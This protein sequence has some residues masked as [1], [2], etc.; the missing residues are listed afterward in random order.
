[1]MVA[2][3]NPRFTAEE[4][5]LFACMR[6]KLTDVHAQHIADAMRHTAIDWE[7]VFK[8]AADQG[9]APL[10]YR[11]L[12]KLA[13]AGLD[14][15]KAT[16]MRL[17]LLQF[18]K[19]A[20]KERYVRMLRDVLAFFNEHELPVMLV[21]GAALDAVV[22]DEPWHTT[23]LDIDVLI[24]PRMEDVPEALREQV[25]QF[26]RTGPFECDFYEHHDLSID[27]VLPIKFALVWEEAREIEYLGKRVH[28][29]SPEDMLIA[30]CT[31]SCRKRYFTLKSLY[32]ISSIVQ[33]YGPFDTERLAER[34]AMHDCQPI[35]Y[36]ALRAAGMTVD[37]PVP[38]ELLR[39]LRVRVG[40]RQL[41][42]FLATA[43]VVLP[44]GPAGGSARPRDDAGAADQ[45]HEM[46]S[47]V[48]VALRL[49][50]QLSGVAARGLA[51]RNTGK[52]A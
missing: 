13:G 8:L 34:A 32:A 28:V 33:K 44:A 39:R 49:L 48:V 31:N 26:N 12:R 15:P 7:V 29:M 35:V 17:K 5:L 45:S 24:K 50:P 43:H 40:R 52:G 10:V 16:L 46:E 30:A 37:C 42:D 21:K 14:V 2:M 18:E 9:V 25:W 23:S 47:I 36:A 3:E 1:M 38:K 6:Q 4:Q 41:I 27:G 22:Y 20:E 19:I 11:H 51:V